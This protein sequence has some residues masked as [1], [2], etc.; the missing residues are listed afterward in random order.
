MQDLVDHLLVALRPYLT[1]KEHL[2]PKMLATMAAL[3]ESLQSSGENLERV[4]STTQTLLCI[5]EDQHS[6]WSLPAS[7]CRP[8][9]RQH[10]SHE[11]LLAM[12]ELEGELWLLPPSLYYVAAFLNAYLP[13]FP[14]SPTFSPMFSCAL[15]DMLSQR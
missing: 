3:A 7:L 13:H 6:S 15:L 9:R 14:D 1:P 12:L 5:W 8:S 4:C 10:P 11:Q 2:V